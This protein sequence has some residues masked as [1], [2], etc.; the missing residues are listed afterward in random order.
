MSTVITTGFGAFGSVNLLPTLG[1]GGV[2]TTQPHGVIVRRGKTFLWPDWKAEQEELLRID[3][4]IAAA[5]DESAEL[6]ASLRQ[7]RRDI[8]GHEEKIRLAEDNIAARA[9][10]A[11]QLKKLNAYR[12]EVKQGLARKARMRE[13]FLKVRAEQ[14][15]ED[16]RVISFIIGEWYE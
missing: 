2:V 14:E 6:L 1:F 10:Y 13:E 5:K 11:D 12:R 4:E 7:A 9:Y 8:L 16:L 3:G 15:D